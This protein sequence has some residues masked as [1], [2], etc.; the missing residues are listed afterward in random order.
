MLRPTYDV[1]VTFNNTG[2]YIVEEVVE[3]LR[4]PDLVLGGAS[5]RKDAMEG[6]TGSSSGPAKPVVITNTSFLAFENKAILEFDAG[7]DVYFPL[8]FLWLNPTG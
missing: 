1:A 4:I 3:V 2:V 5:F 7:E 6:G 8:F